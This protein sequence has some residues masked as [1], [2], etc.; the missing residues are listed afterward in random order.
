ME[1]NVEVL[2]VGGG[3]IGLTTAYFLARD[4]VH[5]RIVDRSDL[6]QEASWAGAG[7]IPPGNPAAART[8]FDR[9]RALGDGLF[10]TLSAELAELTGI[11][12][13]YRR[14]GGLELWH[15]ATPSEEWH[16]EGVRT[17]L[18]DEAEVRRLEPHLAAGLGRAVHLPDMAQVRNPRHIKALIAACQF[19]GVE[20]TPGCAVHGF[21]VEGDRI[22]GVKTSAGI[23]RGNKI[24]LATGAWTDPLLEPLGWRPGIEPVRGQIALLRPGQQ[25][26]QRVIVRGSRYLVPRPDGRVLIGST[27]ENAGYDKRTTATAIHDLLELAISIVPALGSAPLERS[28]AGLRPG[29]PDG[30]PFLGWLPGVANL[31]VA[32]GH[33]RSGIQL[34]TGTGLLLRDLLLGRPASMAMEPFRLDRGAGRITPDSSV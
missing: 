20:L 25:L 11:D 3:I 23:L 31:F 33:F 22:E 27:E 10:A 14:C 32:A 8:P 28:W 30:L 15:P 4:G 34:S 1:K 29:S 12:N 16:G 18:L 6:G 2:V 5:V 26:F 21:V 7:I 13:G 19:K 17:E 9:L 24:V